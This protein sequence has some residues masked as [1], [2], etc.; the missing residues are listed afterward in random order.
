[1]ELALAHYSFEGDPAQ[2]QLSFAASDLLRVEQRTAEWWLVSPTSSV[3][4]RRSVTADERAAQGISGGLLSGWAPVG[5]LEPIGSSA[6][7]AASALAEA[8][9][10]VPVGECGA[11]HVTCPTDVEVPIEREKQFPTPL[12]ERFPCFS[13]GYQCYD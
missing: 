5:Y 3:D 9:G 6:A 7:Q 1:M 13:A 2:G 11:N 10:Q 12:E 8:A 4:P